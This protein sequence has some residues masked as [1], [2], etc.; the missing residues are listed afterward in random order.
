MIGDYPLE[1]DITNADQ[2]P[3]VW[4]LVLVADDRDQQDVLK[5]VYATEDG[6]V[7]A[8][9]KLIRSDE[10]FRKLLE[11]QVWPLQP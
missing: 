10:W 7:T 8:E 4:L 11:I 2:K 9:A 1:S 6:A 3:T 5:G